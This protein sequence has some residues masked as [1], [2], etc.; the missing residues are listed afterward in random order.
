MG[1]LLALGHARPFSGSVTMS[2]RHLPA[3]SPSQERLIVALL[4][5]MHFAHVLDF[6]IMMPLGP[7]LIHALHID[8]PRFGHLVSAYAFAA[9]VSGLFG[10]FFMDRFDRKHALVFLFTGFTIGTLFCGIATDYYWM[11]AARVVAGGFGGILGGV[12]L[13]IIGD[14]FPPERRGAPTGAVMSAFSVASV[15]G[16][17]IGLYIAHHFGWQATFFAISGMSA[18]L[19]PIAILVF[20]P[21]AGHREHAS[22]HAVA[23]FRAI[24]FEPAHWVA[25]VFLFFVVLGG[26]SVIPYMPIYLVQNVGM[27]E[28][29]L[30]WVY[31]AGGVVTF[32][33]S[34]GVGRLADRY[35]KVIIFRI[36]AALAILPILALTNLPP[37][38]IP[39][40]LLVMS[41]FMVLV[42]GRFVPALALITG[43]VEARIRGSFMSV[44]SSVQQLSLGLASLLGG[45]VA[46]SAGEGQPIP[47]YS[48]AGWLAVVSVI[49]SLFL[50]QRLGREK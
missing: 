9:A 26:F 38:P 4:A 42:S 23:L 3:F 25:F 32:F 12:A 48:H 46:G 2:S 31:M 11:I 36:I 19:I 47:H 7:S 16:I 24:F 8:P 45:Y 20:P 43:T 15:V 14:L 1:I 30:F 37:V 40:I 34:H 49:V 41:I 6:V 17:P 39:V 29:D 27:P 33:S 22:L 5:T 18:L 10:A 50:V 13:S 44:N 35:G 21:V 28:P